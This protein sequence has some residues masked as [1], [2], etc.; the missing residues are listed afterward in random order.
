MDACE[1]KYG[2]VTVEGGG[3]ATTYVLL[4]LPVQCIGCVEVK[5]VPVTAEKN[6]PLGP[7]VTLSWASMEDF[8]NN[9][10]PIIK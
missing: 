6:V 4:G 3:K 5:A 2:F 10:Q 7:S 8:N 9:T 1:K